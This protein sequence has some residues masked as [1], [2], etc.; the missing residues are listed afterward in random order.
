MRI[1]ADPGP[2]HCSIKYFFPENFSYLQY[3]IFNFKHFFKLSKGELKQ[4]ETVRNC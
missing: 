3:I 2:K 1:D 4:R